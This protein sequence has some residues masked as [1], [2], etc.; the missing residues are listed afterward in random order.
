VW[1]ARDTG[2]DGHHGIRGDLTPRRVVIVVLEAT[3]LSRRRWVSRQKGSFRGAVRV[4][5]G[6]VDGLRTTWA[7]GYGRWNSGRPDLTRSSGRGYPVVAILR[8]GRAT[9]EVA[10]RQADLGKLAGPF[11]DEGTTVQI[12][13]V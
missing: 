3:L 4:A 12:T 13:T 6:D 8:M 7:R 10:A 2:L 1:W 11:H 5:A 9:L